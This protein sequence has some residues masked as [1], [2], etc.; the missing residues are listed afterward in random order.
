MSLKAHGAVS[1]IACK[2]TVGGVLRY[3]F[4]VNIVDAKS[5]RRNG[6][7]SAAANCPF[8]ASLYLCP[9]D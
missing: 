8:V 7:F 9:C 5:G 2:D 4:G 3:C 6:S 1:I